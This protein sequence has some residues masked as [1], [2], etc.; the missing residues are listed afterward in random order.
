MKKTHSQALQSITETPNELT[1]EI[2]LAPPIGIVRLLRQTD[3]QM[4]T[5]W[6]ALPSIYDRSIL[7]AM[8]K[9]VNWTIDL[10]GSD[11]PRKIVISGAGTSGRLAYFT[12]RTYNGILRRAGQ[13][14]VFDFLIAGGN[15][16]LI[17]A[18]E[19]AEDNPHLGASELAAKFEGVRRGLFIGIT[20]GLSAPYV[21]GQIDWIMNHTEHFGVMMGFNPA[22]RARRVKVEG[23]DKQ[24]GTVVDAMLAMPSR[25]ALLN[26]VC[27]PEAITG[28][29]RMKGG[30]LTKILLDLLFCYALEVSGLL[31]EEEDPDEDGE[32]DVEDLFSNAEAD[33]EEEE[34]LDDWADNLVD[35]QSAREAS[36]RIR[37]FD[38]TIGNPESP[39]EEENDLFPSMVIDRFEDQVRSVYQE[40]EHLARLI[41][42]GG[43]SLR[44]GG[45]IYYI[46][47]GSLGVL[48]L[49]DASECPPTYGDRFED[50]RGFVEGGWN[51][52][53]GP[54]ST[55]PSTEAHYMVDLADYE[56]DILPNLKPV[57]LVVGV[58][59][60]GF[61]AGVERLMLRSL[62]SGAKTAAIWIR[63]PGLI[64]A[65]RVS[66]LDPF[67]SPPPLRNFKDDEA[68]RRIPFGHGWLR[69]TP[70][71]TSL[72]VAPLS[73][74]HFYAPHRL[75]EA[76]LAAKLCFNALTTGAHVL[77]GKVFRNRM[78]DL[79]IS[80][81]KLYY[82][83]LGIVQALAG[84][85]E[86]AARLA[87][88]KSI[89]NKDDLSAEE[90]SAPPSVC[91]PL[92]TWSHRVVPKAILLAASQSKLAEASE[93]LANEPIVRKVIEKIGAG[94]VK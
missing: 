63:C 76:E 1:D 89:F 78:I 66:P 92:A 64:P 4:F 85:D 51:T 22:E 72:C 8:S 81:N 65:D 9:V 61:T 55:P 25:M 48:A 56:R 45:H 17:A 3:A 86:A 32:A 70:E 74:G 27:G 84:V 91:I 49:V 83:T 16:A 82:R 46:G 71:W 2:D 75:A 68:E 14:P 35:I 23:W 47:S 33:D 59:L 19:G 67:S 18:Q 44:H 24:V 79:R 94:K 30:S 42:A 73:T 87:V 20:C 53:L 80:N 6:R 5:G 40:R 54:G 21:A 58:G 60:N 77:A 38:G 29:T 57:D 93:I 28:S 7:S 11:E 10:L 36:D 31:P 43:E 13:E 69:S 26:P 52:I 62:Q 50:V 41:E 37:E 12:A 15:K 88:H 34:A 90:I 39:E